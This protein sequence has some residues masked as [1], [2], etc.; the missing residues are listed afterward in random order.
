MRDG[1]FQAIDVPER[2]KSQHHLWRALKA[3]IFERQL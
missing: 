3:A 1:L 2:G